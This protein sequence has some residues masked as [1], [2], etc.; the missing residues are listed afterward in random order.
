[1]EEYIVKIQNLYNHLIRYVDSVE[2]S[3]DDYQ[4][5][6]FFLNQEQITKN[7][8]DLKL[9]LNLINRITNNHLRQSNLRQNIEKIID[10]IRGDINELLTN[11]ELFYLFVK[12][13]LMLLLLFEKKII[14]IDEDIKN[15]LKII[16]AS[17]YAQFFA[18][19]IN[20]QNDQDPEFNEKRRIGEND[21]EIC[22]I[23]RRDSVP[24][25]TKYIG[26]TNISLSS[27]TKSSIY[28]T[29]S[30]LLNKNIKLIEYAAFFGSIQI[31]K[32][33][34]ENKVELTSSIWPYATHGAKRDIIELIK[35]E[36]I[37]P[38]FL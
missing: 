8:D 13:K 30:F 19:E 20:D 2:N 34:I 36:K 1:M 15:N 23:I 9:L 11:F 25:F 10:K 5:L 26:N 21:S 33:L 17:D 14:I 35:K 12:N 24:D 37:N 27:S 4:M 38:L 16:N 7:K 22:E 18:P 3:N 6:E 29:N 31:F 28:E 32:Y